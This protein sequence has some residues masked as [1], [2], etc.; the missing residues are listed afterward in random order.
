MLLGR[1]FKE[2]CI[3]YI[4]SQGRAPRQLQADWSFSLIIYII[5][6]L[7]HF[8]PFFPEKGRHILMMSDNETVLIRA[9][10]YL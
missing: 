8:S 3:A 7:R 10:G 1:C 9:F 4:R 2:L 5:L 6:S